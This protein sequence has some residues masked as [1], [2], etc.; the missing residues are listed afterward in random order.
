MA[1]RIDRL[2]QLLEE[3]ELDAIWI[4]SPENRRYLSGFTG[5]AGSLVVSANAAYLLSDFRY[6]TQAAREAPGWEFGLIKQHETPEQRLVAQ[7]CNTLGIRTLGFET[8]VSFGRYHALAEALDDLAPDVTLEPTEGVVAALRAIKDDGETAALERAVRITDRA[9]AA[10]RP[11]MRPDMRERDVAWELEKAMREGGAD[12][13]AFSIIVASGLNAGLPHAR[14]GD[15][16]L[17]V[18]RP[19]IIDMGALVG[20][21]HGDMT[22]TV[23]LGHADEQFMHIYNIVLDAQQYAVKHVRAGMKGYEADAL[24]RDRIKA[25]GYDEDAFG[26]GL[27]HGV[28]LAIHEEPRLRLKWEE[29]LPE[30]A[31]F[32]IEP[33][34]YLPDW[35]GVRIE[36]LVVLEANGARTLTQSTKDPVIPLA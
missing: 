22:R 17:G 26:H 24:A 8:D 14:A 30:G 7:L 28:G 33:G 18:G 2:R 10:V 13:I 4:T 32:S 16:L 25:A 6:E 23:V 35:G 21:Y 31:V 11:L 20:G 29:R 3:R 5:S 34:I 12:G 15:D 36:D 19:I 27:G 1:R 9:F